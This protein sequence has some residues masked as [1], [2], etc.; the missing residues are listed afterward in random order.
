MSERVAGRYLLL[1]PLGRGGMGSV[2]LALDLT[3]GAECAL[4]RL[5]GDLPLASADIAQREFDALTRVRHP[6]VVRVFELGRDLDGTSYIT[7]EYVAGAPAGEAVR[8]GDWPAFFSVSAQLAL[9]LDVLHAAQVCHGDLKPANVLVVPPR[10]RG[11]SPEMRLVDFG[12]AGLMQVDGV[13]RHGTPGFA[14]PELVQG[15]RPDAAADLYGLGATLYTLIA[16]APPFAGRH[17]SSTARHQRSGPPPVAPLTD[18][19][20]PDALVRLVL[21]LLA[22]DP[23]ERPRSAREVGRELERMHPAARRSLAERVRHESLVGREHPLAILEARRPA[24]RR[25]PHV[26]VVHGPAGMGKSALLSEMAARGTLARRPVA[27]LSGG[28]LEG[29]GALAM[30]L[31]RRLTVDAGEAAPRVDGARDALAR[32]S[33]QAYEDTMAELVRASSRAARAALA[34]DGIPLVLIDD[35]DALDRA[36]REYLRRLLADPEAPPLHIIAARRGGANEGPDDEALLVASGFGERL[37]LLPFDR[38]ALA[39]LARRRL[40]SEPPAA[41]VDHLWSVSGG[42]PGVAVERLAEAITHG[43]VREEDSGLACD[44]SGLAA[45]ALPPSFEA[46]RLAR[47]AALAPDVAGVAQALALWGRAVPPEE[48][49]ACLPGIA[50][51][52]LEALACAGFAAP[53]SAGAWTLTPPALAA[54]IA[55]AMA[56]RAREALH[57]RLLASSALSARER[58]AHLMGAGDRATAL[59]QAR[60]ALAATFDP[61]F[62]TEAADALAA[63]NPAQAGDWW[64]AAADV[65]IERG[66]HRTAARLMERA[67]SVDPTPAARSRRLSHV[68]TCTRRSEPLDVAERVIAA[69][70]AEPLEPSDRVRVELAH[71]MVLM[72]RNGLRHPAVLAQLETTRERARACGDP[73]ALGTALLTFFMPLA[74]QGRHDECED[75]MRQARDA[76]RAGSDPIGE[77]RAC[78]ALAMAMY[79][80]GEVDS[81]EQLLFESITMARR[82]GARLPWSEQ[83]LMLARVL[84]ETGRWPGCRDCSQE[85]MRIAFEDGRTNDLPRIA[86]NLAIME[87][88]MGHPAR[89]LRHARSALRLATRFDPLVL[90]SARGGA[91]SALR[92][93]GRAE[94]A[95]R[96][97]QRAIARADQRYALENDWVRIEYGRTLAA[98]ERWREAE[99]AWRGGDATAPDSVGRVVRR[100]LAGRAALRAGASERARADLEAVRRWPQLPRAPYAAAVADQLEAELALAHDE[101][102]DLEAARRCLERFSALPAPP[103]R[104]DAALELARL[105]VKRRDA[106]R[107]PIDEWLDAAGAVFARL[108]DHRRRAAAAGLQVDWLR[109]AQPAPAAAGVDR[110]LL[111]AV[112]HL[113]TSLS[114]FRELTERAMQLAVEQMGAERGVLLLSDPD[115][116]RL[117]PS[118]EFG[119]VD[120][121]TRRDALGYSR[122]VVQRVLESGGSLLVDDAPTDPGLRSESVMDLRLLSIVC[123]PMH[124]GG[125]LVGA[126]YLDDSRRTAAFSDADRGLLEGFAQLMAIAIDKSRGHEE[127]QRTNDMLVGENLSLRQEANARYRTPSFIGGSL[128][129]QRVLSAV[130]AAARVNSTVLL[131]GENGTGKDMVARILHHMGKRRSRPFVA[132]NCGAI[133]ATLLEAELFGILANVASDV[134]ARDGKF[135]QADGGTLFLDE[136]GEMPMAQQVALLSVIQSREIV[137]VGGTT[138]IPVDVRIVA[139]TNRDLRRAVEEGRFR[140]DL[141]YRLNV[142]PI[143]LPPLR[144]RKADI[145]ALAHH[146]VAQ[147]SKALERPVPELSPEFLAV[148]MQSDWPGNVRELQNYIERVL[149]M[150]TGSLLRPSPLPRDLEQRGS[151]PAGSPRGLTEATDELERSMILVALESNAGNQSRAAR[152]LGVT[153][154]A[155]RYKLKRLGLTDARRNLRL[156]ISERIAR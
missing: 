75:L 45:L 78:G 55:A 91:A 123:V 103:D 64:E 111:A 52:A 95:R 36:S 96:L 114:D 48:L 100:A 42:V 62:A 141:F 84:S 155:L 35:S 72:S 118:A 9:G 28:A 8:R 140:I 77:A 82:M 65:H 92:T 74:S 152:A 19:G 23:S 50:G 151:T 88:L 25:A 6:S 29:A 98:L 144:E 27:A 41:L 44:A 105:G 11:A 49:A 124:V 116:G 3:T 16:G 76:F 119:G 61:D 139:A 136:V 66:A 1:R 67:L 102:A 57:V 68:A 73:I 58:F 53:D 70:L 110:S 135:V 30:A 71:A 131:T 101:S 128:A 130:E 112:S 117:V 120:A 127:I 18:A 129:M 93:L 59:A 90:P 94:Q 89:G 143:E 15:V 24:S 32:G 99:R 31:T 47:L 122:R 137:P 108:G 121:T 33:G 34:R 46:S 81:S 26:V 37:A 106:A 115:S 134:R 56:S 10:A 21:H 125:R 150:S 51:E 2:H 145:P 80:R 133:P 142:L 146:M 107:L 20:A 138:P 149:A 113:L 79:E 39:E 147:F 22:A 69:A 148:I 83:L 60:A 14:A 17:P 54:P 104:A 7:M 97:A 156:R 40:G 126:V 63:T 153:E 85:A 154:Q 86:A 43:A 4:K 109:R 132:V 87:S 13:R 38:A 5:R 12:L